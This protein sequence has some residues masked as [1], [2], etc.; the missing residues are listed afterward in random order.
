VLGFAALGSLPEHT[1]KALLTEMFQ[2]VQFRPANPKVPPG[3]PGDGSQIEE[4]TTRWQIRQALWFLHT[5]FSQ[6]DD[7]P[8]TG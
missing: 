2:C 7:S 6:A 3:A 5:G 8:T 1:L 4:V